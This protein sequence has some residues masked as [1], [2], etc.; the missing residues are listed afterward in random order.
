[1]AIMA[2]TLMEKTICALCRG[3]EP[4][5]GGIAVPV[6]AAAVGAAAVGLAWIVLGQEPTV[7]GLIGCVVLATAAGVAGW[8]G[9]RMVGRRPEGKSQRF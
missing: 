6:C 2:M 8:L 1:V 4:A 9:A 3:S 7:P 5:A